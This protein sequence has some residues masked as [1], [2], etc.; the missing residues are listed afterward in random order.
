MQ[1]QTALCTCMYRCGSASIY[2]SFS[3]TSLLSSLSG[4][5]GFSSGSSGFSGFSGFSGLGISFLSAVRLNPFIPVHFVYFPKTGAP[6]SA[7]EKKNEQARRYYQ[8]NKGKFRE[9]NALCRKKNKEMLKEYR[10]KNKE[11]KKKYKKLYYEK[12]REKELERSRRN[13]EKNKKKLMQREDEE[14]AEEIKERGG[15]AAG[16]SKAGG[17]KSECCG[18]GWFSPALWREVLGGGSTPNAES[19]YCSL[20]FYLHVLV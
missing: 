18:N 6:R 20:Q 5:S 12:N 2:L 1:M 9:K 4:F 11:N 7:K 15:Q 17:S 14:K 13:Y 3:S 19:L 16:E 8:K 10:E